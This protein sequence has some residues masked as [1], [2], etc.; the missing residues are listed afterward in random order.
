MGKTDVRRERSGADT[1]GFRGSARSGPRRALLMLPML[2]G[3]TILPGASR[4][5]GQEYQVDLD[6]ENRVRFLSDAPLEDFEGVTHR[7]DGFLFLAGEGLQ[8]ETDLSRSEFYFEVDLA[9]L[10]TGIGLRNRH[11]RE[12]YLETDRF[13]FASFTGR[14]SR[15]ERVGLGGFEATAQGRFGV[16]GIERDREIACVGELQGEDLRIRCAFEVLLSDHEIPIPKL[17]F[18]KIDEIMEVDLEFFLTPASVRE[19]R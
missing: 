13:P 1:P 12:N 17:M 10:D 3:V 9:S 4:A 15:L 6:R 19:G 16:H 7:I 5:S 18:M 11:M 14:V 8:G 2:L